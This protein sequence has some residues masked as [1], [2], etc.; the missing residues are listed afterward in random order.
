MKDRRFRI[1]GFEALCSVALAILYFSWWYFSA[2][3]GSSADPV[4]SGMIMGLPKW[5]FM[6]SVLGPFLFCFLAW[7]MVTL[8]FK[9]M[10]ITLEKNDNE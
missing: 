8:L 6:S 10:P 1:A 7:V 9:E 3:G 5:F 4:A 2:Y